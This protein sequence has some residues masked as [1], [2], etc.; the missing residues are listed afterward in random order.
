MSRNLLTA[1]W[2]F[3]PPPFHT[4]LLQLR[5]DEGLETT[6]GLNVPHHKLQHHPEAQ[7]VGKQGKGH[8]AAPPN[9]S[10][11]MPNAHGI[12]TKTLFRSLHIFAFALPPRPAPSIT[13][14]KACRAAAKV[15]TEGNEL[16]PVHFWDGWI[17]ML[18]LV[19]P[20]EV[21]EPQIPCQMAPA[22]CSL[23]IPLAVQHSYG[24]EEHI[25]T[26]GT[27]SSRY[28]CCFSWARESIAV[29]QP[30]VSIGHTLPLAKT[31]ALST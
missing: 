19:C 18:L 22:S 3:S 30:Q 25:S 27:W 21:K 10:A 12:Q 4:L 16:P 24:P 26:R 1:G 8:G 23:R 9:L 20:P 5:A 2:L 6:F 17:W 7:H 29:P 14:S 11:S 13:V 15:H 28:L 31:C